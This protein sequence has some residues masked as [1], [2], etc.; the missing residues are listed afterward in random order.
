M[1]NKIMYIP[2]FGFLLVGIWV[3]SMG[4]LEGG[5]WLSPEGKILCGIEIMLFAFIIFIAYIVVFEDKEKKN[6]NAWKGKCKEILHCM[7][8]NGKGEQIDDVRV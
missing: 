2:V 3:S 4:Y 1:K 5:S 8:K 7:D 6:V